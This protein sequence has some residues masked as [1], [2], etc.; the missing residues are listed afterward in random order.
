MFSSQS[1]LHSKT[2]SMKIGARRIDQRCRHR[3]A[4]HWGIP[5]LAARPL[6]E[7]GFWDSVIENNLG[8]TFLRTKYI[9]PVYGKSVVPATSPNLWGGGRAENNGA[10]PYVVSRGAIRTFTRFSAEEEREWNVCVVAFSPKQAIA[11]ED[12]PEERASVTGPEILGKRL[13]AGRTTRN[14]AHRQNGRTSEHV[15]VD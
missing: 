11:T 5:S 2:S 13:C 4:F 12:A 15:A 7:Q 1:P 10:E 8:G 9:V 3:A 14:G 6:H